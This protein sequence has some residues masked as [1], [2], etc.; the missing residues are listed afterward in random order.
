MLQ[1][2]REVPGEL[3]SLQTADRRWSWE[4]SVSHGRRGTSMQVAASR[5]VPRDVKVDH[6]HVLRDSHKAWLKALCVVC[7][8]QRPWPGDGMPEALRQA[9]L[10][11]APVAAGVLA[12][13][14]TEVNAPP[15]RVRE[16]LDTLDFFRSV[17][18]E[19]V[20]YCGDIPGMSGGQVGGMRYYVFRR[21]GQLSGMVS[22][23][24]AAS[25]GGL[26][27]RR[28]TPPCAETTTRVEP[29]GA[30]TRLEFTMR[31]PG[32]PKCSDDVHRDGHATALAE[33]ASRYKAALERLP[34]LAS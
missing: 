6:E 19:N 3:I 31:C 2:T 15:D 4:L 21:A 33:M 28:L 32:S 14:S 11:I 34:G 9:G 17:Q 10:A 16:A 25:P 8:G 29:S 30:G 7:E 12:S 23:R 1:I 5:V 26:V 24:A 27:A 13:A 20:L 22:L 18:P